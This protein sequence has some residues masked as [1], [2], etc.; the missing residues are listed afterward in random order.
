MVYDMQTE[1]LVGSSCYLVSNEPPVGD[2]SV[3]RTIGVEFVGRIA[4]R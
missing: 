1:Q 3:L 2:V 4:D